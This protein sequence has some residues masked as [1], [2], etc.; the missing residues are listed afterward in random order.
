MYNIRTGPPYYNLILMALQKGIPPQQVINVGKDIETASERVKYAPIFGAYYLVIAEFRN[1]KGYW[2]IVKE[3]EAK[4]YIRLVLLTRTKDD[5]ML[6]NT[7][8]EKSKIQIK[9]Y[10]SYK[11]SVKDKNTYIMLM[12]Q[13]YNPDIKVN[14]SSL[15]AI[16]ERLN[17][18]THEVNGYLQQLAWMPLTAASIR[19]IIPKK[20]NLTVA[21]FNWMLYGGK[22]TLAEAD[23]FI[24]RY[25]YYPQV[26]G[27]TLKKYT[28]MLLGLYRLY[29]KGEFT[30]LNV[31]EFAAI[32]KKTI[33]NVYAAKSYL[34]IF[35][36]MSID[37]LYQIDSMLSEMDNYNK[38]KN[39][40][41]LYKVVRLVGGKI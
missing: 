37:R 38:V 24:L 31:D 35:S 12:L 20:D 33:P 40:L 18:Y 21:S 29:I 9:V 27:E 3:L 19:K 5:F 23:E 30:E 7:K 14:K 22:I 2:Q 28:E 15:D 26:L 39:V 11:A 4:S 41:I 6:V 36:R 34:D 1:N 10:D 17:G 25:R 16:R 32:N 13:K 8:A